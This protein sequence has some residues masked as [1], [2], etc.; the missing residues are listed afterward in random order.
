[1]KWGFCPYYSPGYYSSSFVGEGRSGTSRPTTSSHILLVAHYRYVEPSGPVVA[2]TTVCIW[3]LAVVL[4]PYFYH[5]TCLSYQVKDD[6]EPFFFCYFFFWWTLLTYATREGRS[7]VSL[8]VLPATHSSSTSAPRPGI[9]LGTYP[10]LHLYRSS[11]AG[12][13]FGCLYF[14][15]LLFDGQNRFCASGRPFLISAHLRSFNQGCVIDEVGFGC[16]P[17][18]REI[19]GVCQIA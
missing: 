10:E 7:Q 19:S 12:T 18:E 16:F 5:W 3:D 9:A 17:P 1:M 11:S 14:C 4:L 8:L 6:L 13:G 2:L 15:C